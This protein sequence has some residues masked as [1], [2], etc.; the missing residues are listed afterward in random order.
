MPFGMANGDPNKLQG[1]RR[2]LQT[3]PPRSLGLKYYLK[4][5]TAMVNILMEAGLEPGPRQGPASWDEF[6]K[7]HA[8]TLW[9]C[10]FFSKRILRRLGMPQV[11]AMVFIH[12][13][14]RRVWISPCTVKPTAGWVCQQTRRFLDY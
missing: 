5:F 4:I 8:E 14:T 12:V 7:I 10:D 11:S 13:A 9:Q 6:L 3:R 2:T 1:G